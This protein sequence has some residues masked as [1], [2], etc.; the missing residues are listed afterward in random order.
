MEVCMK[1]WDRFFKKSYIN[2]KEPELEYCEIRFTIGEYELSGTLEYTEFKETAR[3]TYEVDGSFSLETLKVDSV[4]ID[5]FE[6]EE[7]TFAFDFAENRTVKCVISDYAVNSVGTL[8]IKRFSIKDADALEYS[9]FGYFKKNYVSEIPDE[10]EQEEQV[11]FDKN[12]MNDYIKKNSQDDNEN[13]S[14][15]RFNTDSNYNINSR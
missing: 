7:N 8:N 3:E 9:L 5:L 10:P 13:I 14:N 4:E 12:F 2:N 6:D 1:I 11:Y 15:S